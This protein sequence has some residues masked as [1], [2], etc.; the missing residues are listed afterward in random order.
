MITKNKIESAALSR[1]FVPLWVTNFLGAMNDNFLK[2]CVIFA[3]EGWIEDTRVKSVL[4]GIVAGLLVLPYILA[5]PLADRLTVVFAKRRILRL[6]KIAEI[7]IIALAVIGFMLH[8]PTVLIVSV[9]LM[10]L[11]SALYSPAKYALVRDVG[12]AAR[13]SVGM[14]GMEGAAF[15]GVLA[16]T[17]LGSFVTA[18]SPFGAREMG[19]LICAVMGLLASLGVKADEEPN[20]EIHAISPLRF[21]ARAHR[22]IRR[23]EGLRAVIATLSMFWFVAAMLQMGLLIYGRVVLHVSTF[24][25]GLLLCGAAIG[26]VVGQVAAGFLDKRFDLLGLTPFLGIAASVLLAILFVVPLSYSWFAALLAVLALL[27]GFFKLPLDV[28]IQKVVKGYRLN[29]VLA[30]FNQVSFAFM[31]VASGVYA[32]L[33]WWRGPRIFLAFLALLMFATSLVF[34]LSH[35]RVMCRVGKTIFAW[36]YAVKVCGPAASYVTAKTPNETI[37]VLPNHPAMVDPMLVGSTFWRRAL[38]PLS[39]EHFLQRGGISAY[40]L[41]TLGTVA[42]PDLRRHH[43]AAAVQAARGLTRV[44][45]DALSAGKDVIFYPSGHIWTSPR[46]EIG[47]RQ[48]AY[49][50]CGALPQ[51]VRVLG[52]RTEGLWGSIWSRANRTASP[53]FGAT[54]AKS[55]F[56]WFFIAPFI[57][58]R[59]V[60]IWIED[61]TD[62]VTIWSRGTRLEFNHAMEAWYNDSA[63]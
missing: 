36:R 49:N 38:H 21:A 50:V 15:L 63:K 4:T 8:S 12:G 56:L 39:D 37:L 7:P 17:V 44:V 51:N 3:A 1:S 58:R 42:V 62:R 26:I 34:A 33:S 47:T 23:Y 25:T 31:L 52:V 61:L 30:Y 57:R 16:G 9:L 43:S 10:G 32:L 19:L 40:V 35:R 60:T 24:E 41:K 54:L 28:E 5:S 20:R 46:E 48:L 27:F 55:I 45:T 11:Q 59:R 18:T 22:L 14:G 2:T 53:A 6:A 29:T 13:L